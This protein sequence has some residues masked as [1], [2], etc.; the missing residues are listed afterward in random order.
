MKAKKPRHGAFLYGTQLQIFLN[1]YLFKSFPEVI[2]YGSGK[3]NGEGGGIR[4][5]T[6]VHIQKNA[7]VSYTHLDVYKRQGKGVPHHR[8][9]FGRC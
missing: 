1:K 4:M 8:H 6:N 9:R 2:S 7:T 3:M 5:F